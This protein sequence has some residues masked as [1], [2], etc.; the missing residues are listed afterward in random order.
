MVI[1]WKFVYRIYKKEIKYIAEDI[2]HIIEVI[3]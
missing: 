2:L 3:G 1:G